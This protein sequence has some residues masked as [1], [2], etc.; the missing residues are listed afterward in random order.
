MCFSTEKLV[1]HEINVTLI[2]LFDSIA[3]LI[4]VNY[5]GMSNMKILDTEKIGYIRLLSS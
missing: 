4:T 5:D 3:N 1:Y 2:D